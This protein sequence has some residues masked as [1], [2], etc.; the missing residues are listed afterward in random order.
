MYIYIYKENSGIVGE[1]IIIKKIIYLLTRKETRGNKKKIRENEN[2][3]IEIYILCIS[4]EYYI[5]QLSITMI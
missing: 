3:D 5:N 1:N 4:T 2:V